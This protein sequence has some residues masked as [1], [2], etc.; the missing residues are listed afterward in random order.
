MGH[1]YFQWLRKREEIKAR[2]DFIKANEKLG[3]DK[4]GGLK[5]AKKLPKGM[6]CGLTF[7]KEP[8]E[9]PKPIGVKEV[10]A[11]GKGKP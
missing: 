11:E 7:T 9:K 8:K 3:D 1:R 4:A 2:Q 5:L 6:I 10:D